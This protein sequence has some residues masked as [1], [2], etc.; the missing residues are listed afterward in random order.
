MCGMTGAN[1]VKIEEVMHK[2]SVRGKTYDRVDRNVLK[3]FEHVNCA[4]EKYKAWIDTKIHRENE[5]KEPS[6]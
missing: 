6:F 4:R 3:P 5:L 2:H 1:G